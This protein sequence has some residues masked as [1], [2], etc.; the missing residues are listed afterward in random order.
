MNPKKE[1]LWSLWV[2]TKFPPP[3]PPKKKKKKQT[4]TKVCRAP[5]WTSIPAGVNLGNDGLHYRS[6]HTLGFRALGFEVLG[7]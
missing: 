1:L 6:K 5:G 3:P 2:V 4:D 7:L